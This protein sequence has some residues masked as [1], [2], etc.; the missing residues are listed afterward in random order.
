MIKKILARFLTRRPSPPSLFS[1]NNLETCPR[2]ELR[3]R[4]A[5]HTGPG[6]RQGNEA[7]R[8]A[9]ACELLLSVGR[10][11]DALAVLRIGTHGLGGGRRSSPRHRSTPPTRA[12]RR[13]RP[14]HWLCT[15]PGDCGSACTCQT[16]P[17]LCSLVVAQLQASPRQKATFRK[18]PLF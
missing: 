17:F 13:S 10:R 8:L 9:A 16:S 1:C 12:N 5:R 15:L 4:A 14:W 18:R 7:P 2:S 11:H 6:R 3:T